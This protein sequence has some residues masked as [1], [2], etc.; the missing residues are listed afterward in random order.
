MSVVSIFCVISLP[1]V[2]S[3]SREV[4]IRTVGIVFP[5][6]IFVRVHGG[7]SLMGVVMLR[8]KF[9]RGDLLG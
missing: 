5:G 9:M 7:L 6:E 2:E 8:G 3:F 4:V 1:I